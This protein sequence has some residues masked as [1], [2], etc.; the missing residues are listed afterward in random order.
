MNDLPT[1]SKQHII[2]KQSRDILSSALP[3]EWIIRHQ[4]SDDYGI[5][6]EIELVYSNGKVL[7]SFFKAQV[8]GSEIIAKNNNGEITLSGIKQSTLLYWLNISKHIHVIIFYVDVNSQKIYWSPVFWQACKLLD[9]SE[10]TKT[11]KFLFELDGSPESNLILITRVAGE[12]NYNKIRSFKWFLLN[13]RTINQFI[14]WCDNADYGSLV[15]DVFFKSLLSEIEIL[16]EEFTLIKDAPSLDYYFWYS[17][18]NEKAGDAVANFIAKI[19]ID[20]Y[21]GKIISRLI[22]IM[23]NV[24]NSLFFWTYR[25]SVLAELAENLTPIEKTTKEYMIEWVGKNST[26]LDNW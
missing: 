13:F 7:G 2:E 12:N 14:D 11:V 26:Y 19:P 10:S 25:D 5:D 9:N 18:S 6:M 8:K 20:Y 3:K 21:F 1:R 24:K 17:K 15:D 22:I 23:D 4:S 16:C